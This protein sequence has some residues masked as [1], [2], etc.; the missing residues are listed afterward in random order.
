MKTISILMSSGL[1]APA[2]NNWVPFT[3]L[4]CGGEELE[5]ALSLRCT[6]VY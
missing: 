4:W 1:I 2:N 5:K 3:L 6:S